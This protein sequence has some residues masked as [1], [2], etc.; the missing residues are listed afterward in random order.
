MKRLVALAIGFLAAAGLVDSVY[1]ALRHLGV[2]GRETFVVASACEL[3]NGACATAARSSVGAIAGIPAPVL[4]GLYFAAIIVM[5]LARIHFGRWILPYATLGFFAAG[6][7]YSGYLIYVMVAVLSE[8][9]PYCIAAHSINI[10][11]F[12]LYIVSLH[13]DLTGGPTVA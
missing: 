10:V 5:V 4:G 9:C 1:L 11:A 7:L 12:M 8:P 13:L 6:L 2:L 3:G